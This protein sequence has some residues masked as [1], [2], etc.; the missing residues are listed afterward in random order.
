M[1]AGR[2]IFRHALLSVS[3][4]L[5]YLALNRPEVIFISH[6]GFTAWY[7]ATGLVLALMLGVSPWYGLLVGSDVLAAASLYH[8]PL[9][10]LG[11]SVGATGFAICYATAAYVLRG[12]LRI[13]LN[14]RR[15]QDVVRYVFVTM[16]AAAASTAI[17]VTSLAA[18]KAIPWSEFWPSASGW[19]FGDGIG[20]LGVAPFLLIHVFPWIR[21]QLSATADEGQADNERPPGNNIRRDLAALAEAAGQAVALGGVL[22]IIFGPRWGTRELFYLTFVP[23]IWMA[24]RQ[25]SRRVVT[26]LLALNFGIVMAMHLFPP[27]PSQLSKVGLLMLVVSGVGLIVG[28]AVTERHRIGLELQEQTV[29][30]NSLIENS[31]LG[32]V[33][34]DRQGRVELANAAFEKLFLYGQTELAGSS[35]DRMFVPDDGSAESVPLAPQV[36]AGK[37]VH[38]TVRRRRRDGKVIDLEVF[39]VPLAINGQVRGAYK[40]Y[41][42]ISEQL[43]ASEAERRHAEQLG[44]LVKELQLRTDQMTLLNEMG[45]LLECC[46]T[47]TEA[48]TVVAQSVQKLLP[49]ALC[50][51]LYL[52]KS[53]RNLVEAAVRWGNAARRCELPIWR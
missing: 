49:E 25:G 26:G 48:C 31:P 27:T 21:A 41:R 42:D 43:R 46:G 40:I 19:F 5:L 1:H 53:S 44:Q 6:L 8:Q 35:L 16:V 29:Y 13:D 17:G 2:L 33:V 12:P 15:R 50:G 28:S 11:A 38:T 39:A 32:L 7:P 20:L 24:M 14:L 22:W 51:T 34:L 23:V 30:L 18:D 47:T 3:F 9:R 45:D 37:T 4:V 52:F 10:S 36:L